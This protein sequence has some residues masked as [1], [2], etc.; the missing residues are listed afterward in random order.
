MLFRSAVDIATEPTLNLW[1][2]AAVEIIVREAGGLFTNL[3]GKTGPHGGNALAT[4]GLLHE[5]VL[6]ALQ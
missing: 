2:M 4:N 5:Q 1:D 3:D 6:K